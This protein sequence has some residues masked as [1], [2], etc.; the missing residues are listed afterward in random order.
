MYK[1]LKYVNGTD[2]DDPDKQSQLFNPLTADLDYNRCWMLEIKLDRNQQ[3][4]SN[5]IFFP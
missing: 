5:L 4:L 3:D 1:P 2:P